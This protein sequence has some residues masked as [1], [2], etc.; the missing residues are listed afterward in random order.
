MASLLKIATFNC[1]GLAGHKKRNEVFTWLKDKHFHLILLQETHSTETVEKLWMEEWGSKIIFNHGSSNSRGVCILI[2]R[3]LDCDIVETKSIVGGRL[4]LVTV[5]TF[6]QIFNI[7]NIYAPNDDDNMFYD[8]NLKLIES[9]YS[10]N[11][12]IIA[13]DFNCVLDTN[14]DKRGGSHLYNK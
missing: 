6:D 11:P 8:V 4:Q 10:N 9:D 12:C 5:K 14:I 1:R 7:F 2:S 13:G 3:A